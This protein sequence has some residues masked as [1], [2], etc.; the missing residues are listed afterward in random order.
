MANPLPNEKELYERIKEENISI[1]PDIWDLLYH[2]IGDDITAINFLC[3]YYL[4][5]KEPIPVFEAGKILLYTRHIKDIN[6]KFTLYSKTDFAFP[7]FSYGMPLHPVLTD[8]FTHY[9]GNDTYMI[10]LIVEDSID[11]LNPKSVSIENIQKILK[12]THSLRE[13]L[14]RLQ[15]ATSQE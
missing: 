2:R 15:Q 8:M 1:L 6:D 3:Q 11:P 14:N 13:F 5:E 4:D 9:I 7:E 10:N 12:Y